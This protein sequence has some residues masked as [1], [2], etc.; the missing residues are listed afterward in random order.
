MTDTAGMSGLSSRSRAKAWR[1][2]FDSMPNARRDPGTRTA[3]TSGS[4]WTTWPSAECD[5]PALSTTN[6]LTSR[7]ASGSTA[8]PSA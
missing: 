3:T 7:L 4:A 6:W 8:L 1:R 2:F 5:G